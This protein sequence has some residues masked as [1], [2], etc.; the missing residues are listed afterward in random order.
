M[1]TTLLGLPGL[2]VVEVDVEADGGLTVY[3]VTSGSDAACP[4]CG[5][6]PGGVKDCVATTTRDVAFGDRMLTV[7]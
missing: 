5:S 1:A 3:V 4:A 2:R 7:A 6:R